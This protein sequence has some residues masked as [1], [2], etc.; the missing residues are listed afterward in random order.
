M[1][2]A[3]YIAP[4][5]P[6]ALA[7]M[8]RLGGTGTHF[9][10]VDEGKF[11]KLAAESEYDLCAAGDPIEGLVS[12]VEPATS[13]A[14]TIGGIVK[15]GAV[16]ALADGIQATPGTGTIAVGDYVVCG[17]VTARGTD[18]MTFPKV[19]KATNQPG[20]VITVAA[21]AN[22]DSA[23]ATAAFLLMTA[24]LKNAIFGWR[25]VSLGTAGTGAVGTT[26]VIERVAPGG[27]A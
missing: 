13:A 14:F 8:V 3:H 16:F 25:V 1:S 23:E 5:I 2:K 9:A 17:T 20:A 26:I 10:D 4:T 7:Q 15:S 21:D 12:S 19:C 6:M 11:V 22:A 24:Q 27:N 18:L